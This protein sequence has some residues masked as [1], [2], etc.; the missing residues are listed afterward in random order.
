MVGPSG[1]AGRAGSTGAQGVA[2]LTGTQGAS[3]VGAA[4]AI[5]RAG[6][7]GAQGVAGLTGAQGASTVGP[8]GIA[9]TVGEI[10]PQGP[11]G[12]TG[13]QGPAGSVTQWT[14]VRELQ[15]DLNQPDIL[16]SEQTKLAEISRYLLANPSLKVG[17]D[18]SIDPRG[19]EPQNQGLADQ[20]ISAVRSALVQAGVPAEKIQS[21]A[22]LDSNLERHGQLALLIR[23]N[24]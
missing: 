2:G 21:G 9:G 7:T 1:P 5:G 3:T 11:V 16:A 15:F 8:A 18:G 4:G 17:I 20:R 12:A 24:N 10:G 6:E 13:A 19:S 14:M 23:T 22:F